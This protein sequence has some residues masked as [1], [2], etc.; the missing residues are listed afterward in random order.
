MPPL[1][2]KLFTIVSNDHTM[3]ASMIYNLKEKKEAEISHHSN[4]INNT[5]QCLCAPVSGAL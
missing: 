4:I 2:N 3:P 5:N 1:L